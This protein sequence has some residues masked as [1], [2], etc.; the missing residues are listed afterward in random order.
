MQQE[1]AQDIVRQLREREVFA[2][3]HHAGVFRFGVRVVL[4]D[5][6][7]AIWDSDGA[8]GLEAQIM[9]DNMLVGFVSVIPGSESWSASQIVDSIAGAEYGS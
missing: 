1:E 5:G 2:H 3:V 8:A 9:R 7:E 4:P 6:R